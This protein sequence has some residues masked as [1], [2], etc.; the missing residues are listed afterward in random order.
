MAPDSVKL[1]GANSFHSTGMTV[2]CGQ[3]PAIT[4]LVVSRHLVPTTGTVTV[5]CGGA[6][7][8]VVGVRLGTGAISVRLN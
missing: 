1:T 2:V 7:E 5:I 8:A 3:T 4:T 6:V